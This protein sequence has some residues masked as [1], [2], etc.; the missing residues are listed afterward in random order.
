MSG[1]F[2]DTRCMRWRPSSGGSD[3]PM[4]P[5]L[6]PFREAVWELSQ[7]GRAVAYLTTEVTRMRSLAFWIKQEW[8]WYQVNWLDGRRERPDEDYGPKWYPVSDLEQ[9][10][11]EVDEGLVL[12][13]RPV[14]GP[15]RDRLWSEYGPPDFGAWNTR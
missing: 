10:K 15:D 7:A 12:D 4:D 1:R 2:G 13:A 6:D 9:G 3:W 11:F 8:L 14:I 5:R